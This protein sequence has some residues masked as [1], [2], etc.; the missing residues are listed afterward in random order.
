MGVFADFVV[1]ATSSGVDDAA[2]WSVSAVVDTALFAGVSTTGEHAEPIII[3]A[4]IKTVPDL[5]FPIKN[6]PLPQ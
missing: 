5:T 3:R 1:E 2:G 6:L 4:H